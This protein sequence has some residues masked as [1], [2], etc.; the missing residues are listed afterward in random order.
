MKRSLGSLFALV[1]IVGLVTVGCVCSGGNPIGGCLGIFTKPKDLGVSFT[2][3]DI[4][5]A[6][7]KLGI[8]RSSDTLP[9]TTNPA[10]S[11]KWSGSKPVDATFNSRE[12]TAILN[13]QSNWAFNPLKDMQMKVDNSGMAEMSGNLVVERV[14]G[15]AQ[16]FGISQ[17]V[18]KEA[19]DAL[20]AAGG[21]GV[22]LPFYGKYNF[23]VVDN[24]FTAANVQEAML[25][26]INLTREQVQQALPQLMRLAE[27]QT[28]KVPG[29]NV[30]LLEF[31]PNGIKFIGSLPNV[32]YAPAAR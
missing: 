3:A 18:I 16:A 29:Y 6:S 15:F 12:L 32:A 11:I 10:Q 13:T 1:I 14:A 2:A 28:T 22:N 24:K 19:N 8:T 7:S 27:Q 25:G 23:K 20:K 17:D 9:P 26:P 31:V 21:L 30:K 5:S 4:S